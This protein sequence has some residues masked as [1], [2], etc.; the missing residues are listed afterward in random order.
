ML[1]YS[2]VLVIIKRNNKVV[3]CTDIQ[4]GSI[5]IFQIP[6]SI[7]QSFFYCGK[8]CNFEKVMKQIAIETIKGGFFTNES[9]GTRL[10]KP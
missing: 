2:D 8:G 3:C 1:L 10:R 7:C 4:A 6:D 5:C 9:L